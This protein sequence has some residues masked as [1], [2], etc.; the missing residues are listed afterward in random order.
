MPSLVGIPLDFGEVH[1]FLDHLVEGG[2]FTQALNGCDNLL[3]S[4][5]HG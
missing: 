5:V 1:A 3:G 4:R 2:E